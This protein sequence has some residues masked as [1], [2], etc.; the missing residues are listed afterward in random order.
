MRVQVRP[1][2]RDDPAKL[3]LVR[4]RAPSGALVPLR[5]LV[6]ARVG[7][8]PV[9]IDRDSRTRADH[10]LGN[11]DG[12]AAGTADEEVVGFGRELGIARR[13][14]AG[15]DRTDQRLRETIAADRL[16]LHVALI[17]M[18]MIL[19]AQFNSF[20]HPLTIML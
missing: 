9:Q 2:Y 10:R 16:R 18:Y 13:V 19:A 20:V 1:E 3:D 11:L 12:K 17:A 15:G 14:R 4:V 6:T 8:G 7:S 5:N